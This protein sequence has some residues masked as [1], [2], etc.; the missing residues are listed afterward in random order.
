MKAFERKEDLV[1]PPVL[2]APKIG[3]N[4]RM[5]IVAQEHIV[6]A[7]LTQ[8]DKGKKFLVAYY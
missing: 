4:F 5:Y 3:K 1:S 7:V 6:G 2:Q 8:D